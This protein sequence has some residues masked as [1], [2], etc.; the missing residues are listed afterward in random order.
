[1]SADDEMTIDER[2]KY[3]R[4]MN[5]RYVDASRKERGHLLDEME[6]CPAVAMFSA[7]V[8]KSSVSQGLGFL[9]G[10]IGHEEV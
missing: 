10:G 2:F 3:L 7:E 5:K 8:L 4:K 6:T 1:M 9:W